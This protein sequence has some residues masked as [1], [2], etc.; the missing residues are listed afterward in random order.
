MTPVLRVRQEAVASAFSALE[1]R[2]AS[3]SAAV[4]VVGMGY[5]G[6]P[7][8]ISAHEKGFRVVGFD[9]DLSRVSELN[10]G[11]SGIGTIPDWKILGMRRS[12][13]F[14]AT[15]THQE[16]SEPDVILVCVPTPLTR[17]REP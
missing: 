16:L 10:D 3:R 5:V 4:G 9:T 7:L 6:Q 15:T 11:R 2:I 1:A 14:R 8:A 13:R 17:F 12:G